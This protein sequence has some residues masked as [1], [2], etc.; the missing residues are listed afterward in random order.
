MKIS[1]CLLTAFAAVLLSS[2]SSTRHAIQGD[3]PDRVVAFLAH[4][5]RLGGDLAFRSTE[6]RYVS[7]EATEDSLDVERQVRDWFRMAK[8]G[9]FPTFLDGIGASRS[10]T[11]GPGTTGWAWLQEVTVA[12]DRTLQRRVRGGPHP[13][14]T[15]TLAANGLQLSYR[16]DSN[17]LS[18][19]DAAKVQDADAIRWPREMLGALTPIGQNFARLG[20][21]QWNVYEDADG[22]FDVCSMRDFFGFELTCAFER[23]STFPFFVLS[24]TPDRILK[25][26]EHALPD[27]SYVDVWFFNTAGASDEDSE[28]FPFSDVLK[29]SISCSD[30]ITEFQRFTIND[31]EIHGDG[32][33]RPPLKLTIRSD[34]PVS[35][36]K[37]TKLLNL[38]EPM[39]ADP[40]KWP[41]TVR[42]LVEIE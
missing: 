30:D 39:G 20:A 42:E 33:E 25:P 23:G 38:P 14:V 18:A 26:D 8:L 34:E 32:A 15:L 1:I 7:T 31:S 27:E 4:L 17:S 22:A 16:E 37:G 19:V 35:L 11:S 21:A 41:D 10:W 29:I 12:G 40:S 5:E 3:L 24:M 9:D 6:E 28:S 2:P 13:Q 36:Y